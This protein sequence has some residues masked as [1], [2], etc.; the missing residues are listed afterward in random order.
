MCVTL[1]Y[2]KLFSSGLEAD[3]PNFNV[4]YDIFLAVKKLKTRKK[5]SFIIF[6]YFSW[7][8]VRIIDFGK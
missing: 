1:A 5:L 4:A 3:F 2:D 7:I 6:A 8:A